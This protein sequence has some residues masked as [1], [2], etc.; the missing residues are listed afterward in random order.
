MLF[1]VDNYDSFT[2]N[3][4]QYL[5][6]LG[7]DV[8]VARNDT[9]GIEDVRRLDPTAIV[10]SPGP[11]APES[12]GMT[13]GLIRELAGEI[14]ILGVCLGHQ[15]IATAFGGRVVRAPRLVHG[16]TSK[17]I[18][19]ERGLFRGLPNPFEAARYHSLIVEPASLPSC[20]E[21]TAKTWDNE[22][23]AVSHVD[24]PVHGLQFHPESFL[25]TIGKQV[26]ERFLLLTQQ[27]TVSRSEPCEAPSNA[28]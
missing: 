27:V 9:F 11:G 3:L 4:A 22:I 10:L 23:M 25:T 15:A 17:I 18:H 8:H 20:L 7:Q 28:A 12:A 13:L 2:Y 6:E 21:V 19:N 24:L 14:P 26:L 5:S 1:L 16:E